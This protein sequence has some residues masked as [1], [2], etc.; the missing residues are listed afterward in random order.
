[1]LL[2]IQTSSYTPTAIHMSSAVKNNVIE[3][4]LFTRLFYSTK[5]FTTNGLFL[6][7]F[8]QSQIKQI[9]ANLLK[10][11][12]SEKEPSFS[13]CEQTTTNAV[14][15]ISGIWENETKIGLAYKFIHSF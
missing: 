13:A 8:T 6:K 3:N 9:E 12:D 1:M 10:L 14:L 5:N 15:K 11:Y 4:S 7:N 2:V